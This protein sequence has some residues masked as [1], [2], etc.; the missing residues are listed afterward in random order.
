MV[1]FL[2]QFYAGRKVARLWADRP[3]LN[4]YHCCAMKSISFL[5]LL[6]I[7]GFLTYRNLA[8]FLTRH[9]LRAIIDCDDNHVLN[10]HSVRLLLVELSFPSQFYNF[11]FPV[12]PPNLLLAQ[13]IKSTIT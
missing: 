4:R 1:S 7:S 10:P 12:R 3:P 11:S 9:R 2:R 13:R 6:P 5:P 8:S